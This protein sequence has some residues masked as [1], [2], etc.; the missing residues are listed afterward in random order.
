[1]TKLYSL[2]EGPENK[3]WVTAWTLIHFTMGVVA[4][5]C[6]VYFNINTWHALA[7]WMVVHFLYEVKDLTRA[8]ESNSLPNSFGDQAFAALGFGI[9]VLLLG[10]R[11]T[12]T[13]SL[14]TLGAAFAMHT[15]IGGSSFSKLTWW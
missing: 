2:S 14:I 15:L 4:H 6:G 11:N 9:A 5:G 8:K 1:M 3:A 13:V 7:I 10:K 12:P